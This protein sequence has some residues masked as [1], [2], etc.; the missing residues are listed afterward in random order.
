VYLRSSTGR[1]PDLVA[2][3]YSGA[4]RIIVEGKIGPTKQGGI[5]AFFD[6]LPDEPIDRFV[7]T[8]RGGKHGLLTNSTNI[9]EVPPF[10]AVSS[11]AQ[12]NIG[13]EFD[14]V[15]RGQCKKPKKGKH[16]RHHRKTHR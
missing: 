15:L 4:V 8:L 9:C 11:L 16:K 1:L 14:T 10:A 5:D 2:D 3:L 13:A 7:M 6:D 12:N